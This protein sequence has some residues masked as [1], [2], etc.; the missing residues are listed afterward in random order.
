M[1]R[2]GILNGYAG[3]RLAVIQVFG[4]NPCSAT[5]DRGSNNHR[6]PKA[7]PRTVFNQKSLLDILRGCYNAPISEIF[8]NLSC[9]FLR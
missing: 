3:N 8:D 5:L 1:S 7:N 9:L 4:K 6:I 2:E